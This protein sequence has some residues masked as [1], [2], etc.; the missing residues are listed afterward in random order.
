MKKVLLLGAKGNLAGQ[1]L[2]VFRGQYEII[3]L[4]RERLDLFQISKL[5]VLLE[6]Y[7]ASIILNT[8]AYNKVDACEAS[9]SEYEKAYF[10]NVVLPNY[11]ANWCLARGSTLVHYSSDYVF[12]SNDLNHPGFEEQ[13]LVK[14]INKYGL[15]KSLGEKKILDLAN[16]GLAFYIIRTSKLFGPPGKSLNAKLSFFDLM[17]NIASREKKISVVDSEKSCFTYTPDL[18][19][20]SLALLQ[21][22]E[23]F[24]IYHLVN[25]DP[26]TWYQAL[27]ILFEHLKVKDVQ[28]KAVSNLKR[29]AKRPVSSVLKNTKREKLR[30]FTQALFEYYNK[31]NI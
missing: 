7:K 29:E 17:L 25:E 13:D 5:A 19:K 6:E 31:K 16:K 2:N 9:K 15:S 27:I 22:Q 18:A 10:L 21:D 30:P 28:V 12:S 20:A 1:L 14:P 11:L 26:Y 8:V 3:A 4:D 23:K 24:G